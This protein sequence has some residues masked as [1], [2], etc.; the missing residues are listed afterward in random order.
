[1]SDPSRPHLLTAAKLSPMLMPQ[2]DA[3]FVVHD[4]LHE[5]D[6]AAFTAVVPQIRA[7]AASGD[8]RVP[9][10]L[11]ARLP[12]LEM[13]SVMGVGYDGVD[14]AAAKARGVMVTHTPDVL[15]DDVAD[16]ALGLMLCASRQ[17]PAADRWVREGHWAER[18]AMPLARKMSGARL[19][20]VGMGRIGQ[21]IAKRAHFG[22]DMAIRYHTRTPR[23]LPDL[24]KAQRMESLHALMEACD[25]V[26]IAAP[27][28]PQTHHL[29]DAAALA[30]MRPHAHLIN[31]ARGDL[32]DEAALIA[33]LQGG[34]I[35][36]A[37][38]AVYEFEPRVP[39]ELLAMENVVLLPHLGTAALEVRTQMG[40]MAVAN[41]VAFRDGQELPNAV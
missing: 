15:N 13:I 9:A 2:L 32:V 21:A 6:P 29:I 18:G 5:T 31:I 8:S 34:R 27:A 1:M 7:I 36:G 3:A 33:A 41:A 30:A 39:P 16:L 24:P 10:D 23:D 12:A 22:F 40:M 14:V 17:L 19:G 11:I 25:I 38:L 35:A 28:T 20:I 4:R 37:G 26:V